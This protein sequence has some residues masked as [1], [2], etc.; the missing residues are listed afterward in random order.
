M[1]HSLG[2]CSGFSCGTQGFDQEIAVRWL[3]VSVV[4]LQMRLDYEIVLFVER[5][6]LLVV[7]LDMQ[8]HTGDISGDHAILDCPLK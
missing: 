8:Y 5:Q 4:V 1:S 7:A 2:G 6:G 3:Q